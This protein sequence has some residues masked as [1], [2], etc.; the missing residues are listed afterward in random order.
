M[1]NRRRRKS[2]RHS[3]RRLLQDDIDGEQSEFEASRLRSEVKASIEEARA[4]NEHLSSSEAA[5]HSEKI[6]DRSC[7]CDLFVGNLP[8]SAT[9]ISLVTALLKKLGI[10][11]KGNPDYYLHF[12]SVTNENEVFPILKCHIPNPPQ[13]GKSY[14]AFVTVST[15]ELKDD[16]KLMCSREFLV[17]DGRHLRINEP[18]KS[19]SY[20]TYND[21]TAMRVSI[22]E[23]HA[24]FP[25]LQDLPEHEKR[26]YHRLY[27][28]HDN[29]EVLP[30][31]WNSYWQVPEEG[32]SRNIIMEINARKQTISFEFFQNFRKLRLECNMRYLQGKIN[33]HSFENGRES[34]LSVLLKLPPNIYQEDDTK[35][36]LIPNCTLDTFNYKY[37]IIIEGTQSNQLWQLGSESDKKWK[38]IAKTGS[39]LGVC[40]QYR[41]VLQEKNIGKIINKLKSFN[42]IT[43]KDEILNRIKVLSLNVEHGWSGD[44]ESD[45]ILDLLPSDIKYLIHCLVSQ[46]RM[47]FAFCDKQI[48]T[49]FSALIRK[50]MKASLWALAQMDSH[51]S[52]SFYL[53]PASVLR[54]WLG[55][56]QLFEENEE[57]DE[58]DYQSI[59]IKCVSITPLRVV[60]HQ[61]RLSSSNRMLRMFTNL[62]DRFLRVSFTDENLGSF[63]NAKSTNTIEHVKKCLQN[64]IEVSGKKFHFFAYSNSQLREQSCWMYH[65]KPE[66]GVVIPS[67]AELRKLV[68]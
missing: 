14:F 21:Y 67:I 23:I 40:L 19:N 18:K 3:S 46:S 15:Q 20:R 12:E 53:N 34:V 30:I 60:C 39:S 57:I 66:N 51:W 27:H 52:P 1:T 11:R 49:E 22:K 65:Q 43:R 55:S 26:S 63:Y 62:N 56:Y 48:V 13:H 9:S 28:F 36:A 31:S 37:P 58:D 42:L 7:L 32:Q 8:Y 45:E 68:S 41:I 16:L 61:P 29:S 64:G 35:L 54:K 2:R 44:K 38:R 33:F 47:N 17:M 4:L 59:H 50:N 10:Y 24:G 25:L 6:N 5:K